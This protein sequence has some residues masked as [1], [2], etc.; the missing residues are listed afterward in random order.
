MR[1]VAAVPPDRAALRVAFDA[2]PDRADRLV[3]VAAI[4]PEA[5]PHADLSGFTGAGIRLLDSAMT[6]L[7]RLD[8]S[9]GR[10]H[11]TALVLGSFRRR[12]GGDWDFVVG[13]RGYPGGLAQLVRDHGIDV[14]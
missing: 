13:G 14:E 1:T 8:V 10:P 12:A 3:L 7:G 9:D 11:E 6:E 2:L 5:A 4:D